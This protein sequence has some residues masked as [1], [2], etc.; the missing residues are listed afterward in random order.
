RLASLVLRTPEGSASSPLLPRIAGKRYLFPR[1]DRK[2]ESITLE[3]EG[4]GI[5]LVVRQDGVERRI[6]CGSGRWKRGRFPLGAR[7]EGPG[8][9]SGAWVAEDTYVAKLCH[10]ESPFC[11]TLKLRFAGDQVTRE[12]QTNV[13]FGPTLEQPLV[14]RSGD[15][16]EQ[17]NSDWLHDS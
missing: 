16:A 14:G 4:G 13:G 10:H 5:A 11:E 17:R 1:N 2:V 9:A 8:A 7:P 12:A 15:A 3:A 6:A